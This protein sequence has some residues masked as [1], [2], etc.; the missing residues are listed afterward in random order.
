[1]GH[2]VHVRGLSVHTSA[3][4]R[5]VDDISFTLHEAERVALVGASGSGKSLTAAAVLGTLPVTLNACGSIRVCGCDVRPG[6]LPRSR[7]GVA[8]VHQDP[9]TA[10]NPLVRIGDQL[11][12]VLRA[13]GTRAAVA[14]TVATGLLQDVGFDDPETLLRRYP[15]E[16]SGGQRQR[17]CLAIALAGRPR[18]LIADEPTTAL[19]VDT[20][21]Q[22]L[23]AIERV[24]QRHGTA[25]ML[26]THDR[27]VAATRT[28]R[29]I[30]MAQGRLVDE[31][32]EADV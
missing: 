28:D 9:S 25:L 17:V 5:L 27:R 29:A 20:Q 12:L 6:R 18:L 24:R 32:V 26:I 3:G 11:D 22:V 15:A 4:A 7:V 13:H 30:R 2:A 1:M 31:A 23:D 19:D 16:L 8:A 21:E 10:L 14:T